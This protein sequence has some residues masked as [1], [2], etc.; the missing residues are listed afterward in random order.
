M[1]ATTDSTV[2]TYTASLYL[3]LRPKF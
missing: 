2:R 3:L 1:T